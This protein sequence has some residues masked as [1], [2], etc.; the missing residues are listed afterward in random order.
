MKRSEATGTSKSPKRAPDPQSDVT[1]KDAGK[2]AKLDG[3]SK[4]MEVKE[5]CKVSIFVLVVIS[6]AFSNKCCSFF[7]QEIC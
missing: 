3:K 6:V 2:K 1:Q 7:F 5:L 4:M